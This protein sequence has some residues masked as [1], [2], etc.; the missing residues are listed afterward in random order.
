M[1]ADRKRLKWLITCGAVTSVVDT[2]CSSG[3]MAPS[4]VRA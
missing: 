2:T 1:A 3:T 4:R